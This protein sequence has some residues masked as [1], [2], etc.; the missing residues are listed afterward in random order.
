M[1]V[2]RPYAERRCI[3]CH[4]SNFSQRLKG[5][6]SGICTACHKGFLQKAKFIHAP[7]ADGQ[8]TICHEPHQGKEPHLLVKN[9]RD[10]CFDCH[11]PDAVF[12]TK[13][14][15]ESPTRACT[16]CHDPHMEDGKFRLFPP[17]QNSPVRRMTPEK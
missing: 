17:G 10:L 6:V 5:D 7:V 13:A 2:H 4:A 11:K 1:V 12:K 14:C 8:C 16:E 15:A 9:V 3:E